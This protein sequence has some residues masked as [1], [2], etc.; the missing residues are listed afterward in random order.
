[1][2][3]SLSDLQ[4]IRNLSR[5]TAVRSL[6]PDTLRAAEVDVPHAEMQNLQ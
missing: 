2:L 1:M 5:S 3:K 6:Q 4:V